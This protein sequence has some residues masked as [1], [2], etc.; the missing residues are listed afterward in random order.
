MY[1]FATP[2]VFLGGCVREVSLNLRMKKTI[3]THPMSEI[4]FEKNSMGGVHTHTYKTLK[5]TFRIHFDSSFGHRHPE[6][7]RKLA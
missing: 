4:A 3:L 1:L 6:Y 5:C 7:K 2:V